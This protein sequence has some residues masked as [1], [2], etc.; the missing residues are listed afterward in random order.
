MANEEQNAKGRGM[1]GLTLYPPPTIVFSVPPSAHGHYSTVSSLLPLV[2]VCPLLILSP[3]SLSSQ[4]NILHFFSL[5][6]PLMKI[7]FG[8]SG[9]HELT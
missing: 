1:I 4:Q 3:F 5:G 2:Q 7:R 6:A 9:S 8:D